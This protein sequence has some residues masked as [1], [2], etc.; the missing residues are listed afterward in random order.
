MYAPIVIFAFNRLEPLERCV[1]SL[2]MNAESTAS[3]LIV[4]VDGPRKNKEGEEEKVVAVREYV[5]RITGFK[6]LT[7]HFSEE[8]NKLGP[9]I[10]A[11]VTEVINEYG[12]AIVIEDDLILGS[13]FL[14]FINQGLDLYESKKDVFSVCG[15]TSKVKRPKDY[16]YDAYFCSR[17]S[18]WGWATWK[19]RWDSVDWNLKDWNQVKKNAQSFKRWGGS[20]L[21]SMLNAW[22]KGLNQSWAIRFSFNQFVQDKVALFPMI[23]HVKNDG[24]DGDGTNCKKWSRFKYEFDDSDN[25]LFNFPNDVIRNKRLYKE[26]LKY[27]SIWIRVY[28]K[29]MYVWYDLKEII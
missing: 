29:L 6:S 5:K 10:I 22:K 9:S 7:Y 13:N 15:Y 27:H 26:A 19:D 11:G 16:P 1:A 4:F 21:F 28:S 18:S 2:K 3:D 12:R 14:G 17:S 20:D 25:K 23:S 8:N 24:F